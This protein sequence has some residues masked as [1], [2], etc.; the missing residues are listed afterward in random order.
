M[1]S[2]NLRSTC[3]CRSGSGRCTLLRTTSARADE[4]A[5]AQVLTSTTR[6]GGRTAG[7]ASS[8]ASLDLSTMTTWVPP[9]GPSQV[10]CSTRRI[11]FDVFNDTASSCQ[12]HW[13]VRAK[14][15]RWQVSLLQHKKS[16]TGRC[17]MPSGYTCC[18]TMNSLSKRPHSG[19]PSG[20]TCRH[21]MNSL[22]KRPH[23][24]HIPDYPDHI[25]AVD[26]IPDHHA[27]NFGVTGRCQK[28]YASCSCK[29]KCKCK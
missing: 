8:P 28:S 23:S 12:N 17:S 25:V 15:C 5:L 14:C 20:Y 1:L 19:Q 13:S 26:H 4:I 24:G 7:Q 10:G 11:P 2:S 9:P 6:C 29:C 27:Q 21:A 18:H 3:S 16:P 22:F